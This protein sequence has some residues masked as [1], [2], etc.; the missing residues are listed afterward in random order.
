MRKIT[1]TL[2]CL[3]ATGCSPKVGPVNVSHDSISY[4]EAVKSG[5]DKQLLM[6][7]V[8][9]RYRD[10]PT[11]LEVGVISSAYDFSRSLSS[12]FIT[13]TTD[14]TAIG[15][16]PTVGVSYS[17]KPTT[18]YNPLT[19]K[20]FVDRLLSPVRFDTVLLLNSSGWRIDRLL[21]CV[22]Q[23]MN[24]IR[25][26]PTASGPTPEQVPQYQEFLQLMDI[27]VEFENKDAIHLFK[28]Q[29]AESKKPY[30]ILSIDPNGVDLQLMTRFWEM[31][32]LDPGTYQFYLTRFAG[33]KHGGNEIAIETRSPL[34]LM[35][36][37]SH[38]VEPPMI[39]EMCGR[40]TLTLNEYG[41]V[42]DWNRV[43]TDLMEV[44]SIPIRKRCQRFPL[45][46]VA[47]KY[48]GAYFYIDDSDLHSKSTF[49]LLAQLL[50]L[51]TGCPE[52]P[53]L[54]LPIGQ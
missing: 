52:L 41:E 35:Y 20:S 29:D 51:Q 15:W 45:G 44:K 50:A 10:T 32:E 17:E 7:M 1:L 3:L 49:S 25:Y 23:R 37:L 28:K 53:V 30:Y 6:N 38:S 54:T 40:V 13:G 9:L 21:R 12:K 46:A 39:D 24:N 19:G 47:V 11:F 14:V 4:N 2:L 33:K 27:F 5:V 43:L 42:F 8:R 26:A 31:L 22:V 34:G 18:T 16:E 48:R 36:F